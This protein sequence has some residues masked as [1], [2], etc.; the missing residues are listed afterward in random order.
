ME[1]SPD[2][3]P[4]PIPQSRPWRRVA[5]VIL[6]LNAFV[7]FLFLFHNYGITILPPQRIVIHPE[8]IT[9][10][11]GEKSFANVY[12][13]DRSEPD[14]WWKP[15]S[16][17]ELFEDGSRLRS[18]LFLNDEVRLVGGDRWT[19]EPGRILFASTDNSDP[20]KNGRTYSL[21]SP[22]FY[23]RKIG[24]AAA[25]T[26]AAAVLGLILV[27]GKL[28]RAV[29][30][31][32]PAPGRDGRTSSR[33]RWHLL[34]ASGLLLVGLYC[35][36]GTLSPYGNTSFGH[37]TKETGYLYNSDHSHFRV[38]F[39]FVDHAPK[40]VWDHA[41]LLRRVLYV[42]IAWPFMKIGGFEIGGTIASLVFNVA[43]FAWAMG[44]LRRRIGERG[45]IFAAWL[46]A[47]YP[48]AMYWGGLPYPYA[49]IF[50][51]SLL[52]TIALMDLPG[53][54]WGPLCAVSLAMGIAYLSYDLV[55]FFLPASLV[56]LLWMR[57]PG[58]AAVT[59]VLQVV[60]SLCWLLYLSRVLGQNL[61]NTNTQVFGVIFNSYFNVRDKAAWWAYAS[62]F[63]NVGLDVWFG[64]N[65]I[66]LPALFLAVLALNPVTSRIRFAPAEIAL[67]FVTVGL[68]LFNNL[69]PDYYGATSWV[70]RGTWISRLYQP[71]FPVLILFAARWWQAMPPLDWPRRSIVWL[72]LGGVCMGNALV[73]FGPILNNPLK[74]SEHAF[75]RFYN[76]TD[77]HWLYE[78]HLRDYGRRPIGFPQPQP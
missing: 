4:V 61:D 14:V 71:V 42:V 49:L 34:G 35:N 26:F 56:L 55:V 18:R 19:H 30:V 66:F 74:V 2:P 25:V 23:T 33:L 9:P 46:S 8:E 73:V 60:P 13:F 15:R 53:L 41:L 20:R 3:S 64:A 69:A 47:L 40:K 75:Y 28:P 5:N 37:L 21:L 39:D 63:P 58:A 57:R 11:P 36:T 31:P 44:L 78:A 38:L 6:G 7:A 72:T 54:R 10:L 77:L 62:D 27:N 43:G 12:P 68:F 45:A 52:L 22:R 48:G 51:L 24:Y 16:Q 76:H 65:F 17:V 1:P 67:L 50:P 59:M 70:M 29:S 32:P